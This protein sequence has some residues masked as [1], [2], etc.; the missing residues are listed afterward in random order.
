MKHALMNQLKGPASTLAKALL[1]NFACIALVVSEARATDFWIAQSTAWHDVKCESAP[2]YVEQTY[3]NEITLRVYPIVT[4]PTNWPFRVVWRSST[5]VSTCDE[6]QREIFR[7][8]Y[9]HPYFADFQADLSSAETNR[10]IQEMARRIR[11]AHSLP[12]DTPL[13][14]KLF[15]SY[16]GDYAWHE[17]EAIV[18][19]VIS[20]SGGRLYDARNIR[21]HMRSADSMFGSVPHP[22]RFAPRGR[23]SARGVFHACVCA[24]I[25][26]PSGRGLPTE[27]AREIQRSGYQCRFVD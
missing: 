18:R 23:V 17:Q 9:H 11:V 5:V 24:S 15:I 4:F 14:V 25:C 13:E 21:D 20:Y 19:F 2:A 1:L 27:V 6:Q 16:D 22:N 3:P 26:A 8:R 10:A 12:M 7:Q